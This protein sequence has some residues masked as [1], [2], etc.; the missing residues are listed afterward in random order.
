MINKQLFFSFFLIILCISCATESIDIQKKW[1]VK[2]YDISSY[3]E[4]NTLSSEQ[5]QNLHVILKSVLNLAYFDLQADG[6]Y[7]ALTGPDLSIKGKWIQSEDGEGFTLIPNER[8]DGTTRSNS[9]D[10]LEY[11]KQSMRVQDKDK[12]ILVLESE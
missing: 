11:S 1:I 8:D 2:D 4:A 6:T 7:T 5:V 12:L 3:E 10:I 9:Y